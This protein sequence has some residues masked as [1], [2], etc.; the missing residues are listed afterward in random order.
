MTH[1][2]YIFT[3][4]L[5]AGTMFACHRKCVALGQTRP[6]ACA[7]SRLV[8]VSQIK[9]EK[10][11]TSKMATKAYQNHA[12][13]VM[14]TSSFDDASIRTVDPAPAAFSL[15][16]ALHGAVGL[17]F[18]A[19]PATCLSTIYLSVP[20]NTLI[21]SLAIMTGGVHLYG[22]LFAHVLV[23]AADHGRL[24]SNT[25]RRIA[26]GLGAWS[27]FCMLKMALV[28][29]SASMAPL[30]ANLYGGLCA[31]TLGTM[32]M[33]AKG[34]LLD[35]VGWNPL[36]II[37]LD[38]IYGFASIL[39]VFASFAVWYQ[40]FLPESFLGS[41]L[42]NLSWI[43]VPAGGLGKELIQFLS[44]GGF[45]LFSAFVT[46]LDAA[47]RNRLGAS[48]FKLLNLGTGLLGGLWTFCLYRLLSSSSAKFLVF[49]EVFASFD[50]YLGH[51]MDIFT[52]KTSMV[53]PIVAV[54]CL[55]QWAVA[56]K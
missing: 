7:R 18:L 54:V 51:L 43:Q 24:T 20:G 53:F 50:T 2:C 47:Q 22:A 5:N 45:M 4:G 14:V 52:F 40:F 49:G 23:S 46:L 34:Q 6:Q 32:F 36:K 29:P 28:T 25:Y 15:L 21:S 42:G 11:S 9:K 30:Y 44:A 35:F 3:I 1:V 26:F 10:R 33:C 12:N 38:N 31:V 16:R 27:F 48:T 56:K 8:S 19:F 39:T 13:A 41:Q 17:A 37:S 55:W